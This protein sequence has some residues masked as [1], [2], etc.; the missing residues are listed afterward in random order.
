MHEEGEDDIQEPVKKFFR[1]SEKLLAKLSKYFDDLD[2][3][4][5][6]GH[7]L[8][9]EYE[10]AAE[11]ILAIHCEQIV[12]D[13]SQVL[14]RLL[15]DYINKINTH[16]LSSSFFDLPGRKTDLILAKHCLKLLNPELA[17]DRTGDTAIYYLLKYLNL[18]PEKLDIKQ[19][20]T[21]ILC[22]FFL[23]TGTILMAS[24]KS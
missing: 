18:H 10:I 8:Q 21:Q 5:E 20:A 11:T 15:E 4:S 2:S 12:T 17:S 16:L 22:A 9:K 7:E 19:G 3:D 23:C 14:I 24:L 13:A 6:E 1:T